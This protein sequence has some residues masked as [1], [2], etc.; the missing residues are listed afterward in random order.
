[1][2]IEVFFASNKIRVKV[3]QNMTEYSIPG[4]EL[5]QNNSKRKKGK[6]GRSN[7]EINPI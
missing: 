1:M 2:R 7:K 4:V 6:I 3:L 5:M